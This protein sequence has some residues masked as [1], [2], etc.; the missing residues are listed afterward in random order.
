MLCGDTVWYGVL[1]CVVGYHVVLCNMVLCCVVSSCDMMTW[2]VS[3]CAVK[4]GA[5]CRVTPWYVV[6]CHGVVLGCY[7]LWCVVLRCVA[8]L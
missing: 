5:L 4:C 6:L 7:V 3:W 1:S 2:R 8:V